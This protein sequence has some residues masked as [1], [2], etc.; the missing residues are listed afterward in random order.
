LLAAADVVTA[1]GLARLRQARYKGWSGKLGKRIP[2]GA[3][4]TMSP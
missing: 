1:G 3:A 4:S 2:S